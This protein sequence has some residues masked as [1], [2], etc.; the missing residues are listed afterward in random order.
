MA[1]TG[2][3]SRRVAL[4][5]FAPRPAV[6]Y[7]VVQVPSTKLPGLL[8]WVPK[9]RP[10]VKSAEAMLTYLIGY[11]PGASVEG[12]GDEGDE[13]DEGDTLEQEHARE[14]EYLAGDEAF[15]SN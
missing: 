11:P 14:G 15:R 4:F 9:P 6:R 10:A 2:T 7:E 3:T 8:K 1:G 5:A 13:G 12:L